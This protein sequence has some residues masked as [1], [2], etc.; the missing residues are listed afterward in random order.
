M[1]ADGEFEKSRICSSNAPDDAAKI[2][3]EESGHLQII[4]QSLKK[5]S[6]PHAAHLLTKSA[7][8]TDIPSSSK[9]F[10]KQKDQL[11]CRQP[12]AFEKNRKSKR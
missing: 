7:E 2:L 6:E 5:R 12:F 9:A 3:S 1:V 4:A 11:S 8:D 10:K